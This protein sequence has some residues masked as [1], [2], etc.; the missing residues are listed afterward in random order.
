MVFALPCVMC[1]GG[2]AKSEWSH[3]ARQ[4]SIGPYRLLSFPRGVIPEN[5]RLEPLSTR[6]CGFCHPSFALAMVSLWQRKLFGGVRFQMTFVIFMDGV[7]RLRPAGF[8]YQV[9]AKCKAVHKS[10][11]LPA[12]RNGHRRLA[13]H[14]AHIGRICRGHLSG[15]IPCFLHQL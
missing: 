1:R 3:A 6:A 10:V 8:P 4:R 14:G 5:L 11:A 13:L 7:N 2:K 15:G 12:G 9:A